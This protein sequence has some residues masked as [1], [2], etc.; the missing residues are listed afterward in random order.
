VW[1]ALCALSWRWI[2]ASQRQSVPEQRLPSRLIEPASI[3][4]GN[5]LLVL[6]AR[7]DVVNEV[8]VYSFVLGSVCE[9]RKVWSGS[10]TP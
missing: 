2:E 4:E 10:V 3:P 6:K 7:C 1:R 5:T 8:E 9:F